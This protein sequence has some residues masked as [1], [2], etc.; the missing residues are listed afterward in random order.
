ME[1]LGFWVTYNGVNPINKNFDAADVP[2]GILQVYKFSKLLLKY[3]R[4]QIT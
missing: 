4:K 1:Y 3:V 2:K